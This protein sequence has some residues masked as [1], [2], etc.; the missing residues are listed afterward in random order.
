MFLLPFWKLTCKYL[1]L[2][3][4]FFLKKKKRFR[5]F[6]WFWFWFLLHAFQASLT[7]RRKWRCSAQRTCDGFFQRG[8]FYRNKGCIFSQKPPSL[9]ASVLFS[10]ELNATRES[11][12]WTLLHFFL[13]NT[14]HR[15]LLKKNKKHWSQSSKMEE[16]APL[17]AAHRPCEL[18]GATHWVMRGLARQS[19]FLFFF[20]LD[21]LRRRHVGASLHSLKPTV[22]SSIK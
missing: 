13:K 19:N 16:G 9:S 10:E 12:C 21:F 5:C 1:L 3:S 11:F 2:I 7:R 14:Q 20:G 22:H 18:T 17:G 15:F 6:L 8:S 4:F